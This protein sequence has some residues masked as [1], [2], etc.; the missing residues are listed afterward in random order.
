M[1][2]VV[3]R[4]T[5]ETKVKA[6]YVKS[7][8]LDFAVLETLVHPSVD[9]PFSGMQVKWAVNAGPAMMQPAVRSRDFVYVESTG[10]T[11]MSTGERVGFQLLHSIYLPGAPE[12]HKYKF[13]RGNMTLYHLFW[14]KSDGVVELYIKAFIDLMGAV[15]LCMATMLSTSGVV[16]VSKLGEYALMKKLNWLLHQRGEIVPSDRFKLCHVCSK[17]IK[18]TIMR[19]RTCKVCMSKCCTRCCVSTTM[20][21]VAPQSQGVAQKIVNVC[22]NCIQTASFINGLDVAKD[23]LLNGSKQFKAYVYWS[24]T[25]MTTSTLSLRM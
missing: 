19:R 17:I 25:S 6:A 2:A 3:N 18:S 5:E 15:P 24:T 11:T 8:M 12:L 23:E 4:T 10:M 14:Q 7:N 9:D 22:K 21:F 16:L 20:F 13:V 1:F